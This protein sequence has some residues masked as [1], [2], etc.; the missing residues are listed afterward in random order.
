L[1][2][3]QTRLGHLNDRAQLIAFV[4][5]RPDAPPA[6]VERLEARRRGSVAAL[7]RRPVAVAAPPARRSRAP[8]A[9]RGPAASPGPA[10][11]LGPLTACVPPSPRVGGDGEPRPRSRADHPAVAR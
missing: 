9:P 8:R 11:G 10:P 1:R 6:L 2:R 4:S 3:W 7:R 5:A